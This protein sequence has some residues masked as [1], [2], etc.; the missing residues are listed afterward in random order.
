[1]ETHSPLERDGHPHSEAEQQEAVQEL[2]SPEQLC[3]PEGT[4]LFIGDFNVGKS[5]VLNALMRRNLLFTSREE[6]RTPPVFMVRTGDA[7]ITYAGYNPDEKD[8]VEQSHAQFLSMRRHG[9]TECP[10]T[11][12]SAQIPHFPFTG[13]MLVDTPGTSTEI[14]QQC[15]LP[16][17]AALE[18]SLVVLVTTVEYWAARHTLALITEYTERFAGRFL[19]VANMA[20][21]L[22]H[23]ELLRIRDKAAKRIESLSQAAAP[24]FYIVSAKLE[25]ARRDPDDEYRRRVKSEVRDLCDAGFDALRVA[26]YEFEAASQRP[27]EMSPLNSFVHPLLSALT[28][29]NQQEQEA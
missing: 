28:S 27:C 2:V 6:S 7:K 15:L 25:H 9:R 13:M 21:Q 24:P 26:L 8:F 17:D 18:K 10:F 1:M 4:A 3:A 29:L 16:K 22:N 19:V 5:S 12:L 14:Q 20:D 23:G 11:A